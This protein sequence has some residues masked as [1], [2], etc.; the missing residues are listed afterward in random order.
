MTNPVFEGILNRLDLVVL[1][2]LPHGLFLR[3]GTAQPPSW[4]NDVLA[5]RGNEPVTV[6][7]ALPFVEHFLDD[8]EVFWREGRNGRLRSEVFSITDAAGA[9]IGLVALAIVIGHRHILVLEPI[10]DFEDRRRAL[11]SARESVLDH[12]AHLR[13]TRALLPRIDTART[14]SDQLANSGLTPGQQQ[15]AV[16]IGQQLSALAGAVE[17]LA[18]LPEG[19]TRGRRG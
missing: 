2:R 10:A 11:Q 1:E 4:F 6:G 8:A 13:Q 5:P 9:E 19:V 17:A 12:E 18:P 3:L 7:Q 14:L 16:E 15:L